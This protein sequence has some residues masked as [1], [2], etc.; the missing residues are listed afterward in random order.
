MGWCMGRCIQSNIVQ[1]TI[2]QSIVQAKIVQ[3]RIVHAKIVQARVVEWVSTKGAL[4]CACH[5]L[6]ITLEA[7]VGGDALVALLWKAWFCLKANVTSSTTHDGI[8]Q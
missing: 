6:L 1:A 4:A 5:T 2:V 8:D 3:S 7:H